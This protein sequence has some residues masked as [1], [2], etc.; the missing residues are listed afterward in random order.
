M[1]RRPVRN[2][3]AS[4]SR[5]KP[6][7]ATPS[8]SS[9]ALDPS[10]GGSGQK[11]SRF[12][13]LK[14][15]RRRKKSSRD[16]AGESLSSSDSSSV[17]SLRASPSKEVED[18]TEVVLL[19]EEK[20]GQAEREVAQL[21]ER[22]REAEEVKRRSG[23]SKSGEC[24]ECDHKDGVIS[25]MY[26]RVKQLQEKLDRRAFPRARNNSQDVVEEKGRKLDL[27]QVMRN[28]S[29]LNNL[30][31]ENGSQV[32]L[33]R[34]DG[35]N[36]VARFQRAAA[37]VR[38]TFYRDG[39]RLDD[40]GRLRAY[41]EP[42]SRVFLA[43]LSDGFF[44]SELQGEHPDGV[45]LLPVDRRREEGKVGGVWSFAQAPVVAF[46]GK[47]RILRSGAERSKISKR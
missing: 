20:L 42:A 23:K 18:F 17:A 3:A 41:S 26:D 25:E 1:L 30:L 31:A 11:P 5:R 37:P 34:G 14:D 33:P 46:M 10:I 43:D 4:A 12:V 36:N 15:D 32:D 16:S 19:L 44:P 29:E 21:R 27:D 35:A 39:F 8:F 13:P 6:D 24:A 22:L 7:G 9:L 45:A 2:L 40:G 38:V 28:M 47:G